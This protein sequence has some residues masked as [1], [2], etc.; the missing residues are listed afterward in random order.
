MKALGKCVNW[1]PLKQSKLRDLEHGETGSS[2]GL[3]LQ[4]SITMLVRQSPIG[5]S[6]RPALGRTADFPVP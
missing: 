3:V 4:S 1:K 5:V 6:D 2:Q